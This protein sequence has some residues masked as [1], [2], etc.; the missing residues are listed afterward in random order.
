MKSKKLEIIHSNVVK[1]KMRLLLALILLAGVGLSSVL[2]YFFDSGKKITLKPIKN[3]KESEIYIGYMDVVMSV[4]F[5]PKKFPND[6]SFNFFLASGSADGRNSGRITLWLNNNSENT[7]EIKTNADLEK[8][9]V[10]T[11]NKVVRKIAF[12]PNGNLLASISDDNTVKILDLEELS[13]TQSKILDRKDPQ[14]IW[15]MDI[16]QDGK[17]LA[18]GQSNNRILV[19]NLESPEA[20]PN[21]FLC[22]DPNSHKVGSHIFSVVFYLFV[23]F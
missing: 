10:K 20:Q 15:S 7:K 11:A 18:V 14:T 12:S 21:Q 22:T 5:R 2:V 13:P 23:S 8:I 16:S 17:F 3:I 1:N 4:A 9:S 6:D 19:K